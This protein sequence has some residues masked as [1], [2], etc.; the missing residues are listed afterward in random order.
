VELAIRSV[1]ASA[2]SQPPPSAK[3]LMQR[4]R[5]AAILYQ[6]KDPLARGPRAVP[7]PEAKG[8]A[9]SPKCPLPATKAFSPAPVSRNSAYFGI[10]LKVEE[11]LLQLRHAL[12]VERV[13]NLGPVKCDHRQ[14][15]SQF[16]SEYSPKTMSFHS[17][18]EGQSL[19]HFAIGVSE[20]TELDA[21]IPQRMAAT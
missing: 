2:S 4:S 16:V 19:E 13:E 17:G 5:L 20:E 7:L 12:T 10:L 11:D 14:S 9:S 21:A 8:I 3:P 1:Q 6:V 18:G 15:G